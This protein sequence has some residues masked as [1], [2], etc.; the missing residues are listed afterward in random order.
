[1]PDL[2]GPGPSWMYYS[3]AAGLWMY[4]ITS[5]FSKRVTNSA[6]MN[7]VLNYGQPG[8]KAGSKDR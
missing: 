8:W 4:V 2:V 7:Q 5:V 1:M 3:F 6:I